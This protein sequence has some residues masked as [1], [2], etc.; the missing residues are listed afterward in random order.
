M[1]GIPRRLPASVY[2]RRR[3]AVFGGLLAVIAVIVLIIWRPSFGGVTAKPAE[4]ATDGPTAVIA[5]AV[6]DIEVTAHTDQDSYASG[7]LPSLWLSVKNVGAVEC[8]LPVGSDVQEYTIDSGSRESPDVWW[9]SAHCQAAGVP[10]LITLK[11]GEERSTT[12]LSWDRTRSAPDTC[13]S[14]RPAAPGGGASYHLSVKVGVFEST[15]TKQF[16]LE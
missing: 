15:A 13:E 9:S 4:E 10:M 14:A 16:F 5:C 7:V 11:P 2:R 8:E 6:G 12:P 1:S 3:L